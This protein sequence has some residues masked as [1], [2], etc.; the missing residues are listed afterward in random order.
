MFDATS[1]GLL[2]CM[3]E[4]RKP[5]YLEH[6]HEAVMRGFACELDQDEIPFFLHSFRRLTLSATGICFVLNVDKTLTP[7]IGVKDIQDHSKASVEIFPG[8]YIFGF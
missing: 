7:N 5:S 8:Q 6:G 4:S 2:P 3:H 1:S